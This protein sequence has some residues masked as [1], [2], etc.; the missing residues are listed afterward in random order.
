ME[1]LIH[2]GID[3]VK[4]DGEHFTVHTQTKAKAK[5]GDLLLEFDRQ[6]IERA[7]YSLSRPAASR[8]ASRRASWIRSVVPSAFHRLKYQ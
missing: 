6:G 7:G 4:L 3:T 2:A 1:L 8:T 5:K